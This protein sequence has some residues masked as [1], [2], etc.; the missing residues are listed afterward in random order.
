MIQKQIAAG[1]I[2]Y[3]GKILIGQRKKGKDLEFLW[4]LPGGKLEKGET[5]Q[6]CLKREL[7]EEMGLTVKVGSLFMQKA[8][9]YDFGSFVINA[10]FA[11]AK[12]FDIPKICEH[13]QVLWIYPQDL[14][15][16]EFSPA[17]VPIIKAYIDSLG[18]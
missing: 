7:M 18:A 12:S 14:L 9:D 16:Y 8:Y 1:I 10:F 6:E 13:E 15:K 2:T 4:E 3:A 11:E 17:D 5:L